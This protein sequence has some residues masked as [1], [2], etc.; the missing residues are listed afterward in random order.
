[1]GLDERNADRFRQRL[2]GQDQA[3]RRHRIDPADLRDQIVDHGEHGEDIALGN[4]FVLGFREK[5]IV[6][7]VH[8]S[9]MLRVVSWGADAAGTVRF[10]TDMAKDLPASAPRQS[11]ILVST[12]R[13]SGPQGAPML[14]MSSNRATRS[15]RTNNGSRSS[16]PSMIA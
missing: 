16:A 14:V 15:R 5:R 10:G 8:R 12:R 7:G 6:H 9:C 3:L 2:A 13:S 4:S 1:M 11:V